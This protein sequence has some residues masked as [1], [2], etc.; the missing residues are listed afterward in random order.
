MDKATLNKW[1]AAHI[2]EDDQDI[3]DAVEMEWY[4]KSPGAALV[5]LYQCASEGKKVELEINDGKVEVYCGTAEE[6]GA[7]EDL[8]LLVTTACYR[9]FNV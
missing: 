5:L 4:T 6:T 2:G 3:T 9:C 7:L 8:A 1:A